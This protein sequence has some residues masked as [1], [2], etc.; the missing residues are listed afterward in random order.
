M[1]RM[2][3]LIAVALIAVT[4]IAASDAPP[5]NKVATSRGE[6]DLIVYPPAPQASQDGKPLVLFIS[7]EGGWRRF[8]GVLAKWLSDDG[9]WVGGVDA[10]DYF[11]QPQDDRKAL[12]SDF[13]AY[14]GALAAASGRPADAPLVI[15]GFSFGADL[16]PWLAGEGG[17]GARLHGLLMLAPD[18][19][20]SLAFRVMELLGFEQQE[21]VFAVA[22]ALRDAAGLPVLFI[23]GE[24]DASAHTP[25]LAEKAAQ[26]SRL[27][28]IR[29]ADHHF[30]GHEA[31]LRGALLD[32]LGWIESHGSTGSR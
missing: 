10:I 8:D 4:A 2:P 27:V 7:G 16:A 26:P 9:Y 6:F 21:H 32:G 25:V 19:I 30:T 5:V 13:R 3:V 12:A 11:W 29:G 24:K 22:D 31:E 20:G 1:K 15:A 28:T 14:A 18:R 23:H 17:W